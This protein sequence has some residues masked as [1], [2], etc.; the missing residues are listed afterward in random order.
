MTHNDFHILNHLV[1]PLGAFLS[2]LKSGTPSVMRRKI[3][4]DSDEEEEAPVKGT[5]EEV[6]E[7]VELREG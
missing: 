3:I 6:K 7:T 4:T 5:A 2:D 1:T